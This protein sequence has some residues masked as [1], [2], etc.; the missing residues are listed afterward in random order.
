MHDRIYH[1]SSDIPLTHL[2]S[3]NY[4][5]NK[6]IQ[7]TGDHMGVPQCDSAK[8]VAVPNYIKF[9]KFD[10]PLMLKTLQI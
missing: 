8:S 9:C 2:Q 7:G 4:V 3:S 10:D 5:P 6:A 1:D